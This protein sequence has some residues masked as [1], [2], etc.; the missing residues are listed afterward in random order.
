MPASR[1]F[2]KIAFRQGRARKRNN[3]AMALLS[4]A[5][6]GV[7]FSF[8]FP[9]SWERW[10]IGLIIGLVWGNAFEYAYHRWLLHRP[11]SSFGKGHLEHHVH[12][13]APDEPEHVSLGKSP[14]QIAILFVSNGIF[15]VLIDFLLSIPVNPGIFV[16]WTVYLITAEEIHWRIHLNGWLPPGLRFARAYHMAHHDLPNTR[17]NV[18]LP[19]FDL[20]CRSGGPREQTV[21]V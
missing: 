3:A 17:Y 7:I 4:G 20:L 21:V 9:S 14:V 15:V 10:F 13:G 5:L 11:R 1:E 18:F 16:G 12:T 2:D 6:P 19:L 8:Y